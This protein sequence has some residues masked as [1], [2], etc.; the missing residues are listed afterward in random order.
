MEV[1]A[2]PSTATPPTMPTII[3]AALDDYC[4]HLPDCNE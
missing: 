4:S 1:P 2:S 3:A